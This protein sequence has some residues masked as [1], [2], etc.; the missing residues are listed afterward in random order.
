[1]RLTALG[2]VTCLLLRAVPG[3]S[4]EPERL[5]GA[6]VS[7]AV[8]GVVET[9]RTPGQHAGVIL[10]PGAAGW[11][12]AYADLAETLADSGFVTLALDYYAIG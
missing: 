8:W 2:L 6:G 5:S 11:R 9:P 12:L 7:P 4:Q 10:L 3:E 1:M